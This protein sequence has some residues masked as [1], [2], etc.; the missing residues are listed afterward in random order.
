[1]NPGLLYLVCAA[2]WVLAVV[3]LGCALARIRQGRGDR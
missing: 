3:A 1:M 2:V